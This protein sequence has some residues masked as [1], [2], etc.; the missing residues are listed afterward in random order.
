MKGVE[1][2]EAVV[3]SGGGAKGAYEVGVLRALTEGASPSTCGRPL[4]PAIYTGASVGAYNAA[5]LA[6]QSEPAVAAV[7]RL[8]LIWRSRIANTAESCGNGVFR[9]RGA[10][11]Q[12]ADPGCLLHPLDEVRE[13]T[14]D[15]GAFAEYFT[16]RAT[17]FLTS[18]ATPRTRVLQS[19][20]LSAFVSTAPL[21]ELVG[22]T[23]DRSRLAASAMALVVVASD[24]RS[25]TARLFQKSE[26]VGAV[27]FDA[28]V[29]SA[30]IPGLFQPVVIAGTPFVDGGV[31]MN[32]PMRPAIGEGA[33]V[34][35]VIYLDPKVED[36]P[37]PALPNTFDTLYRIYSIQVAAGFGHDIALADSINREIAL[38]ERL[39]LLVGGR[40]A[41]AALEDLG[42]VSRVLQRH[43]EGRPYR[44]LEI[45]RYRPRIDLGG[46][47]GLLDF[48][49]ENIAALIALGYQDAL[50][51]DCG[52]GE[53]LIPARLGVGR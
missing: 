22:D 36:I 29:A 37:F 35:H 30:S 47:E 10:P 7:Q 3:L 44:P 18:T 42:S 31:V 25:G 20:D 19:F 13:L 50:D 24:W 53:C 32:T 40:L 23:L 5:F 52:A 41:Q 33:D 1:A 39:G 51:H 26:I 46:G 8:E 6:S 16:T 21:W 12:L 49:A 45:H 48:R 15:A 34:L 17:Q 28:V 14:R 4:T 38:H 43:A 11:F 9:L 2:T 27:G